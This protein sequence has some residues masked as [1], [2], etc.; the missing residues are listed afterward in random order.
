LRIV[1]WNVNS[2]RARL[3]RVL[4]LL[5]EHR[6]DVALL[7]ETKTT[8]DGFPIDELEQAGYGAVHNSAGQWAGVALLA[9]SGLELADPVLGLEGDP[10]P[11]EARWCEATVDGIRCASVY[12]PNG[13]SPDSPEFPRKLA[14]L[15]ALERRVATLSAAPLVVAGDFNIAPA[16]RDVYDPAAF[17]SSTHVTPQERERLAAILDDGLVDAYRELHPDEVQYTWWD[18]RAGNFHKGLGLRIDLALLSRD[19][20]GELSE[21]GIDRD[22]RKGSKPSDHAPLL[23]ALKG[24]AADAWIPVRRPGQRR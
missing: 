14:F 24:E 3:P 16:D 11:G 18:Y 19:L 6:P 4:E 7:Q 8:P 15:D 12:V 21:C 17:A 10:V 23:V 9:R 22:Y 2:L 13:R 1:T 5:A 20:A